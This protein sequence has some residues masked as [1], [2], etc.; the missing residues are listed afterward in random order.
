MVASRQDVLDSLAAQR[1][2]LK[3]LGV[4]KLSLFGSA[5]RD[6]LT[7]Q[8]DLDVLVEFAPKTFDRYMDVKFLLEDV[9]GRRVDLVL[10][11]TLKPQLKTA[12]LRDRIDVEGF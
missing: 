11:E 6:Q 12:I 4:R 3:F 10:P 5:A 9:L 7:D 2:R 1:E 8:S